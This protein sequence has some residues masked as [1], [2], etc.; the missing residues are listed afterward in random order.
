MTQPKVSQKPTNPVSIVMPPKDTDP[1]PIPPRLRGLAPSKL[2]G[3]LEGA[4]EKAPS[5]PGWRILGIAGHGGFGTVW[6]A[7]R[8]PDGEMA[9]VKLA[10]PDDPDT[11][12]RIDAEATVLASLDHPDI[13][14]LLD[15]G[16]LDDGEG[17]MFLAMEFIDGV[18]L[19]QM[20]PAEGLEPDRAF[21]WFLRIAGA[22]SQ[23]HDAG[24][25]HRDLKP[26]NILVDQSGG[27]HVADFGLA[28]PVHQRVH[29]LSLTRAD[30]VA[31]TAEYL[32][33]EAYHRG[34]RP[35]VA[36]DVFALGV[37][38]H[39]MLRGAPPRG[40]WPPVSTIR[41]VDVRIDEIIRRALD[42]DPARRWPDVKAMMNAVELVR[43]SPPRFDGTPLVTRGVRA[44]DAI[45]TLLGIGALV[46]G[47]IGVDHFNQS[48]GDPSR[49]FLSVHGRLLGGFTALFVTLMLLL[50]VSLWEICRLWRFRGV[51]LREALPMPF[52]LRPGFNRPAA[53]LAAAGQILF[54]VLPA[55]AC[56]VL[57][58][59]T[60]REWLHAGDPPWMQ[61]LVATQWDDAS[62]VIDPWQPGEP[63]KRYWLMENFGPPGHPFAGTVSRIEFFPLVTPLIMTLS[64]IV[65][66]AAFAGAIFFALRSWWV[67]RRVMAVALA[68]VA[69][70]AFPILR[71]VAAHDVRAAS[72]PRAN[73]GRFMTPLL[74]LRRSLL[75][76]A[77]RCP[78]DEALRAAAHLYAEQVDYRDQGKLTRM[79]ILRTLGSRFAPGTDSLDLGTTTDWNPEHHTFLSRSEAIAFTCHA[80]GIVADVVSLE[81]ECV[82]GGGGFP[83]ILREKW[84]K[85]PLY[86]A[87]PILT[88]AEAAE[89]WSAGFRDMVRSGT[90]PA[91]ESWR[92]LFHDRQIRLAGDASMTLA[93]R[94][95]KQISSI[96][97]QLVRTPPR[98]LDAPVEIRG[99]QPGGRTRIAIPVYT[100]QPRSRRWWVADLIHADGQ[101]RAVNLFIESR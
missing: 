13:V 92:S 73:L 41:R 23:A 33:P 76:L 100:N 59:E 30:M 12:E 93:E 64:G 16:P 8:E 91:H 26:G 45:W 7:V 77:P 87:D 85:E 72:P 28:L 21:A 40:A 39:E 42:P 88:D 81:F 29:Q 95:W 60:C 82:E 68:I 20:I 53:V 17:G 55:C 98:F 24:I 71:S 54:L 75:G 56:V 34:Y 90:S 38:L 74:P 37:I 2:L 31:G 11:L 70:L 97:D 3:V 22:V 67:R 25:L 9:A 36:A 49:A 15:S 51:P 52:G 69:P 66:I 78:E 6:K 61:G 99:P 5:I 89:Q 83:L 84:N 19:S 86:H 35:T 96:L 101:W 58:F 65:T 10:R 32:P 14:R 63:G 50:P 79:E 43:K 80:D 46:C 62:R 44:M 48:G 57:V 94:S 4:T 1:E 27:I 18:E 47:I